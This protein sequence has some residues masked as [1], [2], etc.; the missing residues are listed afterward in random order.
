MHNRPAFSVFDLLVVLAL[1]SVIASVTAPRLVNAR[2]AYAA[3]AARDAAAA[4]VERARSLASSRG[5]ARLIV[6]PA[7]GELRLEA[8]AGVVVRIPLAVE[9][10]F[11]VQ[12][13]VDGTRSGA[14]ELDFN[15]MGLGV[16]ANRTL[17]FR[18][19]DEEARLSLS[20]YGRA[21]RW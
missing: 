5:T 9:S 13:S 17:R 3:R 1:L 18:R 7:V 6:D 20:T 11:G 8:P 16:L 14:V 21:R 19:G 15:A 12:L 2:N 10:A 4:W